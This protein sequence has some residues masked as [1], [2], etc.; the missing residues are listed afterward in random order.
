MESEREAERQREIAA[1]RRQAVAN[2]KVDESEQKEREMSTGQR[3]DR[4]QQTLRR[5]LSECQRRLRE[6]ENS[7]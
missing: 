6:L 3:P 2:S 7:N 4:D 1:Q 5:Q